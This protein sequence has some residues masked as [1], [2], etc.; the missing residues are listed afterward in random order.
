MS[1]GLSGKEGGVQGSSTQRK[2]SSKAPAVAL[3]SDSTSGVESLG[4]VNEEENA[5]WGL[6]RLFIQCHEAENKEFKKGAN[7]LLQEESN[8]H[9]EAPDATKASGEIIHGKQ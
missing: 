2:G 9:K 1:T 7:D 3:N 5:F 8:P 4:D 6:V